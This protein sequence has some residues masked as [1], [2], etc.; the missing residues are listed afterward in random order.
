MVK[1]NNYSLRFFLFLALLLG[2]VHLHAQVTN[3]TIYGFRVVEEAPIF[4]DCDTLLNILERKNCSEEQVLR[5][6]YNNIIYPDI[7]KTHKLEGLVVVEFMV[8]KE[9]RVINT[10]IIKDIGGGCGAEVLRVVN[11]MNENKTIW[12]AGKQDGQ[13][14]LVKYVL[15]IRFKLS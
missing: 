2:T 15:P 10:K 4:L 12:R 9:G 13:K 1:I 11:K 8:N 14:V 6:V 7:A 5:Y 3:E